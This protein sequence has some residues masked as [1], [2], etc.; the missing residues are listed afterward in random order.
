MRVVG[1][2]HR[3]V[4]C[5]CRRPCCVHAPVLPE[6]REQEGGLE[7]PAGRVHSGAGTV[8]HAGL[9]D[10]RA[11]PAH[12]IRAVVLRRCFPLAPWWQQGWRTR[13]ADDGGQCS[14]PRS[15][16]SATAARLCRACLCAAHAP[17]PC[18]ARTASGLLTPFHPPLFA[19]Q[20][21]RPSPSVPPPHCLPPLLRPSRWAAARRATS[22]TRCPLRSRP[23]RCATTRRLTLC[24]TRAL[25]LRGP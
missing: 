11:A 5:A 19:P 16:F 13:P 4:A 18:A 2:S 6:R 8:V 15:A 21:Q 1:R 24:C 20:Q 22:F 12:S 14:P 3:T 10:A 7:Q 25:R 9:H 23:R 17:L